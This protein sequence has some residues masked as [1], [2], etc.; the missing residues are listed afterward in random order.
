[1]VWSSARRLKEVAACDRPLGLDPNATPEFTHTPGQVGFTPSG[2]Q[3]IVT[4]KANTHAID[5]FAVHGG[6]LSAHPVVNV[7]DGSVPFGFTFD[8]AGHLAVTEAGTN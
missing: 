8:H 7:K 2:R 5:V 1:G 4:T 3:L 6:A